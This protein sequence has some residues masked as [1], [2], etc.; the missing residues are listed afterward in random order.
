MFNILK[1]NKGNLIFVRMVNELHVQNPFMFVTC[2]TLPTFT[3]LIMKHVIV[4][5]FFPNFVM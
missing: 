1:G 4:K 5:V 2:F 3:T